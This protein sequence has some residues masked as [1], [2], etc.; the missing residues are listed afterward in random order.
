M[1]L[2]RITLLVVMASLLTAGLIYSSDSGDND[3]PRWRG[4]NYDGKSLQKGVF[5]FDQGYG[6][7]VVWT[8][9]LGS[10][11]SSISIADGRAVTMFSDST[12]DYVVALDVDN[13]TELWRFK[14]DSTYKGHDG[15]H[16][17]QISTPTIDGDKVYV[18]TIKGHLLAFDAKTGKKLWSRDV[19]SEI[20]PLEPVYGFGSSPIVVGDVLMCQVGDPKTHTICGFDKDTGKLLWSAAAD[21]INYQSPIYATLLGEDQVV[22][23]GDHKIFGVKPANGEILWEYRHNGRKNSFNPIVVSDSEIF[24]NHSFRESALLKFSKSDG[25][26][27]IEEVWKNRNIRGSHNVSVYHDGYIYGYS[28]RFLTCVNAKTGETAWKSRP[29]GAGL[30]MMVDDHLVVLTRQGTLHV[31]KA[32][33]EDYVEL[34]STEVF[35]GLTWTPISFANGSIYARS[36]TEIAR[37]DIAPVAQLTLDQPEI[38]VVNPEGRFAQFV[39]KVEAAPD[40]EKKKMVEEFVNDNPNSPLI[41]EG[42]FAHIYFYGEAKD[43]AMA[44]DMLVSGREVPLTRIPGTDFFFA[45]YDLE[46][47]ARLDYYFRHDFD[48]AITD[49]RNPHSVGSFT[50]PNQQASVLRMPKWKVPTHFDE[51]KEGVARGTIETFEFESATLGNT[52]N[53]HVY[54]PAGYADSKDRYPAVFVNYGNF[55][56]DMGLMPNSLD[57]LIAGGMIH[58]IIMVFVEAP[59]SGQEYSRNGRDNFAK[60]YAE[61]LIPH[62]DGKYR[63]KADADSRLLMGGDEGA[64]AAF[65]AAFTYPDKFHNIAGQ[66]THFFETAGGAELK[67]LVEES[68]KLPINIY[69]EWSENYELRYG[70][71]LSWKDLNVTAHQMLTDKGYNVTAVKT[72]QGFGFGSW[73][74]NTD[75]ILMKFFGKKKTMK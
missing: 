1:K 12:F 7:K 40:A 38:Q 65:F 6:L 31:A 71:G 45:S 46:P 27:Q 67:K 20:K 8:K 66:S 30:I 33:P 56:K 64:F 52:R 9:P 34:A 18:Y 70:N 10:G 36:L 69:M 44:G 50:S 32:S 22:G 63:T 13:G 29:P 60:M 21:T 15:S 5:K 37:I 25:K 53:L 42:K 14:L 28:G 26:Y 58:P 59:Q 23:V 73:R 49:P 55:A 2:L 47:N 3:W 61:E 68:D 11:Y 24:I 4:S 17:G 16:D 41:E 57:N 19:K 48:N 51:P 72:N 62:I 54:L 39:K 35:D 43:M 75:K 74:A